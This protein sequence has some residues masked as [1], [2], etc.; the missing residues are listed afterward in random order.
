MK[1][2]QAVE[3]CMQRCNAEDLLNDGKGH[4]VV[5]HGGWGEI[6]GSTQPNHN[7][8]S[9]QEQQLLARLRRFT[10]KRKTN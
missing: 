7:I 8:A 5:K 4:D 2:L 9:P 10:R 1:C 3:M 6:P